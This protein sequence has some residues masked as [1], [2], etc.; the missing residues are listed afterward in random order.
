M[1]CDKIQLPQLVVLGSV[2]CVCVTLMNC[3][4]RNDC[5]NRGTCDTCT[6]KCIN[7]DTHEVSSGRASIRFI[8][9]TFL[10][11]YEVLCACCTGDQEWSGTDT[12]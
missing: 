10:E 9:H 3:L 6:R 12:R 8:T 11:V 1:M 4:H 2:Q 5:F 7:C